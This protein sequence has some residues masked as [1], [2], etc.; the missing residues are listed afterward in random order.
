MASAIDHRHWMLHACM[1]AMRGSGRVSPNP[2]V[3]AVIVRNG[4]IVS[5]GWHQ[6]YGGLHA[7][8]DALRTFDGVTHE[9]VMYVTLE[10]CAHQGK[11]PACTNALIASGIRCVVMG[12]PDPNPHVRGGGAAIL[13]EHGIDVIADVCRDE[14]AWINR[15]F[16]TWVTENRPY[17]IAKIAST[18]DGSAAATTHGGRW[19]TTAASRM[20]VH[21]IRAEVD[22][23]LTGI[24]TVRA[25]D[26]HLTV[27]HTPGRNPARAI[28]DPLCELPPTSAIA[29]T[30]QDVPTYVLCCRAA[31]SSDHA[32]ALTIRGCIVVPCDGS[33]EELDLRHVRDALAEL[34]M[35]S[36][37][38][39]AGPRLTSAMIDNG[40]VDE[41]ELHIGQGTGDASLTWPDRCINPSTIAFELHH[42]TLCEG[43]THRIF[44]RV[45]S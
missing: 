11:Q 41:I 17:V 43:D 35:T 21:S 7:E 34:G 36:V 25:D 6:Q 42:Q 19:I 9:A 20:R 39:E 4:V 14:C 2:R 8:A 37:L 24:G 10:P 44:T 23:V 30:A 45:L 31:A 33:D 40:L 32:A 28:V 3:G 22:C 15:F 29:S 16:T 13:R 26:P 12:M 27:R 1:L 5:E 18:P 38:I